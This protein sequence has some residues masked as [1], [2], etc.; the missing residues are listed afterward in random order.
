MNT[1][2]KI[3]TIVDAG[4]CIGC[5][6]C[7]ALASRVSMQSTASGSLRPSPIDGF[8]D[9]EESLL[10]SV[11]PGIHITPGLANT[12][13]TDPV[14]GQHLQM[15]YAWATDSQTRYIGATGGVLTALGQY[16]IKSGQVTFV[17]HVKADDQQPLHSHAC[18][19][20]S[21]TQVLDGAGSRYAP[22]APL[23]GLQNALDRNQPFAVIAKPCDLSAIEN[24]AAKDARINQLIRFRLT[25]VCGGQ[26]TAKKAQDVLKK[27]GI[28][29]STVTLYRHRGHGNPGPTRIETDDERSLEISYQDL[30]QDEAGW[31]LESR[32]KLC[33]DAL[34]ECAD[35][36]AAD[37][38]PGGSPT[39]EDDGF[40][41]VV[42]RTEV[43]R[44]LMNQATDAGYITRG[45]P[46]TLDQ[47]ND[48][49]PHQVK[50]KQTLKWRYLGL[51]RAGL[52]IINAPLSRLDTL[53]EQ[54]P[55][56]QRSEETTGAMK[57]FGSARDDS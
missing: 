55:V 28:K 8:T 18:M 54:L 2:T 31:Q 34:G 48:F 25:M 37:V 22:V 35:I 26:S 41:G 44:D 23:T 11:C 17:Y 19:S 39:G 30:W 42:V 4:L 14:W 53:A 38:W 51:E 21:S 49:Q 20:E 3:N 1:P 5:G 52:P 57:R 13:D 6:L 32:C 10:C 16:L 15:H 29:E 12:G 36:A 33:P 46:I 40:N 47:F 45:E 24:M 7:E 50:K 43:G 27:A 9:A 56:E